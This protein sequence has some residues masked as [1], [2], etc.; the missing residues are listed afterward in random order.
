MFPII[1]I[2]CLSSLVL[3]MRIEGLENIV[4]ESDIETYIMNMS[5]EG[6]IIPYHWREFVWW[7]GSRYLYQATSNAV[8]VFVIYD[9]ALILATYLSID[10]IRK[11]FFPEINACTVRYLY[12][13][14][15]LFFP[16]P[17]G[18]HNTYRQILALA[19]F[20]LALGLSKEKAR[21]S[22]FIYLV[23]FFIHN[24]VVLLAPIF[25]MVLN[26]YR[27]QKFAFISLV[28][29]IL[30]IAY[31]SNMADPWI[32]KSTSGEIGR[33]IAYLYL[34]VLL[35]MYV[36]LLIFESQGKD[37]SSWL[38]R[39]LMFTLIA[40]YS[41]CFMI[42][43]S[44]ALERVFFL[45]MAVLFPIFGVYLEARFKPKSAT[46]LIYLHLAISPLFFIY[47]TAIPIPF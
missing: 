21:K 24:S 44:Q 34:G 36:F 1:W 28:I 23:A 25:L 35:S 11:A 3:F 2:V 31:L 45:V 8:T 10:L 15:F 6:P 4:P 37:R 13:G 43:E 17:L 26:N 7:V 33:N 9:F 42:L 16:F 41:G 40:I 19:F 12:F 47:K 14:I 27:Y 32:L 38:L 5:L 20:L 46:R 30:G 18:M 39:K 29:C 22:T